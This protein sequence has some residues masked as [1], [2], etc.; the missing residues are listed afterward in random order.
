M[1]PKLKQIARLTGELFPE[2]ESRCYVD[3]GPVLE[4]AWAVRSGLGWQ[5]KNSCVINK[6]YGSW[7]FLGTIITTAE[8]AP[9]KSAANHCGRCRKCIDACPTGA[10]IS[11]GVVDTRKC[12]GYWTVEAKPHKEFPEVV[13]ENLSGWGF[14]CDICQQVCPWNK[15]HATKS[16]EP[17]FRPR[18]GATSLSKEYIMNLGKEEFLKRFR[19]SPVKRLKLAGLKRNYMYL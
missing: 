2:A 13:A 1:L 5:G 11:P 7:F 15:K 19:K 8:I 9:D 10:I 14:G 3:T 12:I 17:L 18:S 6:R 16:E 4:R